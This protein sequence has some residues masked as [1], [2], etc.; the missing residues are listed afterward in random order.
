[1][2]AAQKKLEK[3]RDDSALARRDDELKV[4]EA[5]A[6]LRKAS[7]KTDAPADL[8]ATV[9]QRQVKLD[10]QAA[11]LTLE[12]AKN[13]ADQTKRSDAEEIQRLTEKATYA[14]HRV[15]ELCQTIAKME[16]TVPRASTIVYP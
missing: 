2:D 12:A 1:A 7:L 3:K 4:A 8:M 9:E 14:K 6:G 5:E 11:K 13:H 15:E 10:E 16:V